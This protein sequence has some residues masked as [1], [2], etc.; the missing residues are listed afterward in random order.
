MEQLNEEQ[1]K[2]SENN[3]LKTPINETKR[4]KKYYF[5]KVIKEIK[6]IR[7]PDFK[8]SKSSLIQT[9]IFTILFT[10]FASLITYGLT[11]LWT[12]LNIL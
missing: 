9:I 6:R 1:I 10:I 3:L 12:L 11:Q 5:R 8:T 4:L 2:I 7:W